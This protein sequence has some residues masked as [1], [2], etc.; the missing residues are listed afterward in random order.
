MSACPEVRDEE[1]YITFKATA[2]DGDDKDGLVHRVLVHKI[3]SLLTAVQYGSTTKKR[4]A[5]SS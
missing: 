5:T 1:N 4:V 2:G 3:R